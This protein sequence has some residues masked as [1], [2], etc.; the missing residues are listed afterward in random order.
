MQVGSDMK[1]QIIIRQ[2]DLVCSLSSRA[3]TG[4]EISEMMQLGDN[5]DHV[6]PGTIAAQSCD[7]LVFVTALHGAA[8]AQHALPQHALVALRLRG[9]EPQ[10]AAMQAWHASPKLEGH[11]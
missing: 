7:I 8:E 6:Y 1:L 2:L 3:A 5:I 9:L 11:L 4:N 10:S